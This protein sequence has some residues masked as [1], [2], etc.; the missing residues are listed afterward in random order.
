MGGRLDYIEVQPVS[1]LVYQH[2]KHLINVFMWPVAGDETSAER[3]E[4]EHGYH[5]DQL[6]KFAGLLRARDSAADGLVVT[7][8]RLLKP[9]R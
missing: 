3:I 2:R 4:T 9:A 6:G 7:L 8:H 1:A 5:V